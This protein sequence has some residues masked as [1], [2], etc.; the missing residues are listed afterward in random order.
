MIVDCHAHYT[1]TPARVA[2]FRALQVIQHLGGHQ[3]APVPPVIQDA[4]LRASIEDNQL[5]RMRE[6]GIDFTIFSPRALG[7]DH[8]NCNEAANITWARYSNELIHR[9]CELYPMQFAGA[10]QLPQAP[11]IRPGGA[12]IDE[13]RRC[14]DE[15]G[16]VAA[17]LN[18]DPTGGRWA[19]PPL[20]DK[21]WWYPLYEQ[22]ALL[23]VPVMIHVS[24]SCNPHFMPEVA[25]H[26][27]NGDTTAF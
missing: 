19:D 9:V 15:L 21:D 25:S 10:C 26:Y 23:D 18:P 22:L 3:E 6:R 24:G 8:H 4:E 1:T 12:V 17:N 14:V 2:D 16:F 13:L 5:Q 7:M 11:G 27:L 20:F